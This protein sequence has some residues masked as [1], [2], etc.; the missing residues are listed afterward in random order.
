MSCRLLKI[1]I[2]WL[3]TSC[4]A[5]LSNNLKLFSMCL[6]NSRENFLF[7]LIVTGRLN[8]SPSCNKHCVSCG[9]DSLD[10]LINH[11][12]CN[13][14]NVVSLSNDSGEINICDLLPTTLSLLIK[15]FCV[16]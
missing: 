8:F 10:K 1:L 15:L 12:L 4:F 5:G 16:G 11:L 13:S 14:C 6:I 7:L 2:H 3:L 9:I